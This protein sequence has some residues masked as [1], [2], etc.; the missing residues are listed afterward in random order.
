MASRLH[1]FAGAV[2]GLLLAASAAPADP[3]A[4]DAVI[5]LAPGAGADSIAA[6]DS[7]ALQQLAAKAKSDSSKW[8]SLEAY[9]ADEGSRELN[10]ALAQRE[11]ENILQRLI[12]FGFPANRIRGTSYGEE[13]RAASNQPRRRVEIRVKK[14]GLFQGSHPG[15]G[16]APSAP[17]RPSRRG[18]HRR[19]RRPGRY[20]APPRETAAWHC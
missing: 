14:L 18:W 11:V 1:Q 16:K 20:A 2:L 5:V 12:S 6:A 3:A 10:L 4:A 9:A 15:G 7:S 8:I 17:R 13:H 19:S